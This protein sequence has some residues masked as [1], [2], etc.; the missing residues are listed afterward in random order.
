MGTFFQPFM[1]ADRQCRL[2][3]QSCQTSTIEDVLD[4]E[5]IESRN[6]PKRIAVQMDCLLGNHLVI[7]H[8]FAVDLLGEFV[9]VV[10]GNVGQCRVPAIEGKPELVETP[11]GR[12]GATSD[13][14]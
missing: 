3:R 11:S 5:I 10:F 4:K 8:S 14:N 2:P 1:V 6:S 9:D 7:S 13:R 12:F